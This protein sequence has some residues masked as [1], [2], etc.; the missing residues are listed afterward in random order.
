MGRSSSSP[1]RLRAGF[2]QEIARRLGCLSTTQRWRQHSLSCKHDLL[3]VIS[4]HIRESHLGWHSRYFDRGQKAPC[5][6]LAS[7]DEN[8]EVFHVRKVR[9]PTRNRSFV[10]IHIMGWT[11]VF[12]LE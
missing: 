6:A 1:N 5:F 7:S 12:C 10:I 2:L 11:Y 8:E 4:F 3:W 9:A